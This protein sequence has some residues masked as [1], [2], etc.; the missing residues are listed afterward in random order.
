MFD[1]ADMLIDRMG[2]RRY[3]VTGVPGFAETDFD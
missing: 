3:T 1:E 2:F